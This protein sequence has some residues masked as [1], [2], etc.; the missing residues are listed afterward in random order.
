MT[1]LVGLPPELATIPPAPTSHD[2][3]QADAKRRAFRRWRYELM[4]H[5]AGV[6]RDL[7]QDPG[8]IPFERAKCAQHPAYFAAIYC[9]MFEPRW[10]AD[11]SVDLPDD[12]DADDP[13]AEFDGLRIPDVPLFTQRNLMATTNADGSFDP[14][15]SPIFGW[16]PFI[17]FEAQ[18][19]VMNQLLWTLSQTDENAD[20]IWSKSRG[21]GASWVVCLLTAWGWAFS[22]QWATPLPWNTLLL[23][24]KEEFVDSKQQKSL[25]W[26][27]RRIIADMPEWAIPSGYTDNN[28]MIQNLSNGNQITGESTN[29]NLGRGDRVTYAAIDE[30]AAI[31]DLAGKWSTLVETT[32]H[33]WVFSTESFDEGRDFHDMQ[34][35]TDSEARP[36]LI[37]TDW[38]TNPLNDDAWLDRQKRRY[39][40][41]PELYQQEVWRNPYTGSTLVYGWASDMRGDDAIKPATGYSGYLAIDPGFR[42]PT[43]I[44]AVQE[45]PHDELFVLDSYAERG[46]EADYFLPLL[47]PEIFDAVDPH[48][49]DRDYIEWSPPVTGAEETAITFS[50]QTREI[51]FAITVAKM[52]RVKYIGDTSGENV[53]GATKDSVYSRWRRYG[54]HVNR[55]RKTGDGVTQ[56]VKIGRTFKGRQEAMNELQ[57]RW[58]FGGTSGARIAL[59]ALKESSFQA[60]PDRPQQSEPRQP[61]HDWTSHYV[62]AMEYLAVYIRQRVLINKRELK[63]A[64]KT[65]MYGSKPRLPVYGRTG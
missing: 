60:V 36:Y 13:D 46:R 27:I 8:L 17:P 29:A 34:S 42:D 30:G 21:W 23:S 32:D 59:K 26:K 38:W 18:V 63:P 33:R 10:R 39:T 12:P 40:L 4:I 1:L 47:K 52:G 24:R 55:D 22:D 7:A 31:P 53:V 19:K 62:T 3:E 20:A 48:W 6:H 11:S 15:T 16:V 5:R 9:R 50:Y 64:K 35:N 41:K 25:F 54:I 37:E 58:R 45:G 56:T 2:D 65:S 43:A 61:S 57:G 51:E 28:M 14:E 49:Q 44:I